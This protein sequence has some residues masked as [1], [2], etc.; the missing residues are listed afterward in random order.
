MD[1]PHELLRVM[2]GY[3]ERSQRVLAEYISPE[4]GISPEQAIDRVLGELDSGTL[5]KTQRQVRELLGEKS[6]FFS[7]E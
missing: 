7:A 6:A 1:K 2:N 5:V 4:S 3:V